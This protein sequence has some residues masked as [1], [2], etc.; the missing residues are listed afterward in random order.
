MAS[1]TQHFRGNGKP[2]HSDDEIIKYIVHNTEA[3]ISFIRQKFNCSPGRAGDLKRVALKKAEAAARTKK[4]GKTDWREWFKDSKS[5]QDLK[6]Q[7]S[8]SQD[9]AIIDVEKLG[10]KGKPIIIQVL[11]DLHIGSMAANY[12][13]IEEI[14]EGI[15]NTPNL[16]VILNGDL[17]ETT[18]MFKNAL[19][20]HS[21]S[22]DIETQHE[23][24]ASWLD[25]IAPKVISA[26]WDNHGVEREEKWGAFSHIKHMLNRRFVYHNGLGRLTVE[27]GKASY[28]LLVSHKITGVS[29]FN[30][31]HGV[32]RMMRLQFPNVDIGI[33]GDYH[34]PDVET[35]YEGDFKRA[36][37]MCGNM[38]INSGYQ[39]RYFTLY[40]KMNMP[41][42]VLFP[43][44][45][46]FSVQMTLGEALGVA[47]LKE[48][49]Y[50]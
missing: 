5:R 46:F 47:S 16:F 18:A 30:R 25:T 22:M 34:T 49:P 43:D 35:Y 7:G 37:L 3:P 4:T 41:C 24:L 50:L 27:H 45:K 1:D 20:V 8:F 42:I 33:T 21:Q 39:K 11:S 29:I 17:T 28:E 23:V 10:M 15:L 38:L 40:S 48:T 2:V 12:D 19:A 31:L 36:C 9:H 14:T 13:A 26:G 32:K 6:K 44:E